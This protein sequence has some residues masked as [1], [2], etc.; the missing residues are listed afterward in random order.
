MQDV[1]QERAQL[2]AVIGAGPAGLAIAKGLKQHGVAYEQPEADDNVGGNWYH[3]VYETA[4]IISS[5]AQKREAAAE[6]TKANCRNTTES[7]LANAGQP[8]PSRLL[9]SVIRRSLSSGL[10]PIPRR[11]ENHVTS[12]KVFDVWHS[13]AGLLEP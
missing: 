7:G 9:D 1:V 8:G 3:G 10:S 13:F 12:K 11:K 6:E 4:H 5:D 2:M